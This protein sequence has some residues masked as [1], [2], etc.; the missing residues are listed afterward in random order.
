MKTLKHIDKTAAFV[1]ESVSVEGI[2]QFQ[3]CTSICPSSCVGRSTY[4]LW[5]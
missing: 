4:T 1:V 5:N 3:V 2:L